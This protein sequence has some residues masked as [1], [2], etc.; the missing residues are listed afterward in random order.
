MA[1]EPQIEPVPKRRRNEALRFI[2]AGGSRDAV[3]DAQAEALD[4]IL[5]AAGRGASRLWW[6]RRGRH[7]VAAAMVLDSPGRVGMLFSCPVDV[8][9]VD[10]DV[11]AEVVRAAALDGLARGRAFVQSL[12]DPEAA[13]K[14]AM[15][16]AAGLEPLAELVYLKLDLSSLA[17]RGE[18]GKLTW[19][20]YREYGEDE[21]AQ[22]IAA[23]YEG[24]LDCPRLTG[25]R[26]M[27]DVIAAH[28]TSGRFSPA[29]WWLVGPAGGE[30]QGSAAGCILVNDIDPLTAELVYMGVVPA[31]RGR[32][33]GEA[34]VQGAGRRV[35][36]R[37]IKTLTAAVDAQNVYAR[38]LYASQGFVE[39]HRRLAYVMLAQGMDSSAADETA[40]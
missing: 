15:L 30:G 38:R 39:T 19:R 22:V 7:C 11:L 14:A 1:K 29:S 5:R 13:H 20:S 34:M 31:C 36:G 12:S 40:D 9:S 23:T 3:A 4:R 26:S 17:G 10:V 35:A 25:V 32:G 28:K 37:G 21:L 16:V 24:S 8:P 6:G 33:F 2:A 27:A 18:A